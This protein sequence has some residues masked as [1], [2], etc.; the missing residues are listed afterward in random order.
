M[1]SYVKPIES[2]FLPFIKEALLAEVVLGNI[3]DL[4][5]AIE[6]TKSTFFYVRMQK[7]PSYYGVKPH[8]NVP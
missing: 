2:S 7:N 5:E 4:R 6:F 3:C 1:L 8:Q